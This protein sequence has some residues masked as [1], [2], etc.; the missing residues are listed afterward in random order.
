MPKKTT[1]G[2][3][4]GQSSSNTSHPPQINVST[5]P[6]FRNIPDDPA[7]KLAHTS[8]A[9][10]SPPRSPPLLAI[11][12]PA[13]TAKTIPAPSISRGGSEVVATRPQNHQKQSVQPISL[14]P[15]SQRDLTVVSENPSTTQN[16]SRKPSPTGL[17]TLPPH[18]N[19]A[20]KP[21][22]PTA[23]TFNLGQSLNVSEV[24]NKISP[25][26]TPPSSNESPIY[27]SDSDKT[28]LHHKTDNV[29]GYF[30]PPPVHHVVETK[31]DSTMERRQDTALSKTQQTGTSKSDH[32]S[33]RPILP[34]RME[35]EGQ[36][37][38]SVPRRSASPNVP[39]PP[40]RPMPTSK[41]YSALPA[42]NKI[43]KIPTDLLPPPPKRNLIPSISAADSKEHLPYKALSA[44]SSTSATPALPIRN[45]SEE[46][47]STSYDNV[48]SHPLTAEVALVEA[49]DNSQPN[50]RPPKTK[51]EASR[52]WTQYDARSMDL[53]G[54]CVCTGGIAFRAWNIANSRMIMNFAPELKEHRI[55]A[56]V[57]KPSSDPEEEGLCVWLGNNAGEIREID[58]KR[59]LILEVK[60]DAHGR[61]EV[62]KIFRHQ[63]S[64]WSLDDEGKLLIWSAGKN[65]SPS[66]KLTPTLFRLARG[67]TCSIVIKDY[68]WIAWSRHIHVYNP[69]AGE[70]GLH[71]ISQPL[72]Q[73]SAAEITCCAT[74]S[75]QFD[76]VY[77]G[78]SDG[79]I[80]VYSVDNFT[81]LSLVSASPYKINC[82]AG[83]GVYL[84][85]GFNTG[86]INVYDTL[87]KPWTVRKE[88]QAHQKYPVSSI[89]VDLSSIWKFGHLQVASLGADNT[90]YFW[91]GL[92]ED[93]WIGKN[94]GHTDD[95]YG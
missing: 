68:L 38:Q 31:R 1:T 15:L 72:S 44:D 32:P 61:R 45:R 84:W 3:G 11:Q 77:F 59:Q 78:H 24:S 16:L 19:R 70:K 65:G 37:L 95:Y 86:I 67:H 63:N 43:A 56:F 48:A 80:S 25:F 34:V 35:K 26:S 64:I 42:H 13:A 20:S 57:F 40:P 2:D 66:L 18:I 30:P 58:L 69:M 76:K 52:I 88:W 9:T 46:V 8:T 91:D 4:Y 49:P 27:D 83:A 39:T 87:T 89:V 85:A 29:G 82:L 28:R 7:A 92:L 71:V 14:A 36:P 6:V 47:K 73:P 33:N 10:W 53:Y 51:C 79:K 12:S 60:P 93:D 54:T 62:V 22:T 90:V 50:R 74:I 75:N 23:S 55:T 41:T 21:G 17:S 5:K 81:C 94:I